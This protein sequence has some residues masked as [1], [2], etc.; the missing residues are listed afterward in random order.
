MIKNRIYI[1]VL[2]GFVFFQGLNAQ[3]TRAVVSNSKEHPGEVINVKWVSQGILYE[4]GVNIYRREQ[5]APFWAKINDVPIVKGQYQ[6]PDSAFLVDTSLQ[7]YIDFA[8]SVSPEELVGMARAFFLLE[9]VYSN[10]FAK[11]IGIQY[12]DSLVEPGKTY[13]YMIKKVKG[14]MEIFE[15]V[16]EPV[17]IGPFVPDSAPKEVRVEALN[18][19]VNIWWKVEYNRFHSLNIYRYSSVDSVPQKINPDPIVLAERMGPDGKMGYPDVY[20]IDRNVNNDT[21]YFYSLAGI[22]FFGR[23]TQHAAPVMASPRNRTPPPAPRVD[24]PE[25][26]LFDIQISWTPGELKKVVGYNVYRTVSIYEDFIKLNN[27]LLSPQAVRFQNTVDKPGH[28]Y[29]YVT[30]VDKNGNE[31]KSNMVMAEVMD[32]WPPPVPQNLS[33]VADSGT[34]TLTWNSVEDEFLEGYRLY[35]TVDA[36]NKDFYVLMNAKPIKDTV[37]VD[38]LPFNA[39]NRF[40]YA[41]VSLDTALNM[42]EFSKPVSAKLPDIVPPDVPFI[43]S[44]ENLEGALE[45]SWLPNLDIDLMGYHL[46]REVSIDSQWVSERINKRIIPVGKHSFTDI[47]VERDTEYQY[48]LKAVDSVG[49]LSAESNHFPAILHSEK[50]EI[51]IDL[52]NI[53]VK[54]NPVTNQVEI[55]WQLNDKEATKGVV[56]FRRNDAGEG[57]HPVSGLLTEKTYSEKIPRS[58]INYYYTVVA[59]AHTGKK[60]TSGEYLVV[61]AE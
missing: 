36:D 46:Y 53:E 26:N 20:F 4:Q 54:L 27:E 31:G 6:I 12:D 42:S 40:Y 28:Y 10:E 52:K 18:K 17:T 45:I 30:S 7:D 19:R 43:K 33:A 38:E 34:I 23:E 32:I 5:F 8:E 60:W 41:V 11:Y 9:S 39:R 50:P 14:D 47:L 51:E 25:I 59:Y 22:D 44:V 24:N 35:R 56:V 37:F 29:Y 48:Y 58:N 61:K 57:L 15:A 21:N 2:L 13:Q 55:S 16:T 49:N 1:I 3:G